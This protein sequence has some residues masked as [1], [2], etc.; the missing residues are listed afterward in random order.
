[1]ISQA[2]QKLKSIANENRLRVLYLIRDNEM[3]VGEIEKMMHLSQSAL[4][5]HLAVL[6]NYDIVST[7]RQA[8]TIYYRLKDGRIRQV[9]ELLSR[10]F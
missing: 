4:S 5:Q 7:R 1:M 8:Q 6:R 3:S 9:I 10:L 2:A